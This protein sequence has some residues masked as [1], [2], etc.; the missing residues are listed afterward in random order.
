MRIFIS[1]ILLLTTNS[2]LGQTII[3]N[4]YRSNPLSLNP[5]L[6]G[7]AVSGHVQLKRIS[8][9]QKYCTEYFSKTINQFSLSGDA[10]VPKIIG[11][12]GFYFTSNFKKEIEYSKY[13]ENKLGVYYSKFIS[14]T[15]MHI[16]KLG[17]NYSV[18]NYDYKNFDGAHFSNFSNTYSSFSTGIVYGRHYFTVGFAG[19]GINRP[20]EEMYFLKSHKRPI[21]W[22][23]FAVANAS[24]SNTLY[25]ETFVNSYFQYDYSSSLILCKLRNFKYALGLHFKYFNSNSNGTSI[26]GGLNGSYFYKK[27]GFNFF[28][29]NRFK[30][31]NHNLQF[32]IGL[33]YLFGRE[34]GRRC[35]PPVLV[36]YRY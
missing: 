35:F 32:E 3:Y 36:G 11:A 16:I 10:F 2:I 34:K 15:P 7:A 13:Y 9:T 31:S 23:A 25:F 5:A 28:I 30:E 18:S 27:I 14:A 24:L 12:I 20:K 33:N 4:D 26:Y 29:E 21:L 17:I 22:S 19:Y 8:I 6:A 1:F